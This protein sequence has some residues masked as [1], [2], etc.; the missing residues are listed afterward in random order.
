MN[1]RSVGPVLYFASQAATKD[2]Q[3][4]FVCAR[5]ADRPLLLDHLNARLAEKKQISIAHS[6]VPPITACLER[7]DAS[8]R[9]RGLATQKAKAEKSQQDRDHGE[10]IRVGDSATNGL[11]QRLV[12]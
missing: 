6:K 9:R 1:I 11:T 2:G 12:D 8:S 10:T 7:I 5:E 3:L 4:N